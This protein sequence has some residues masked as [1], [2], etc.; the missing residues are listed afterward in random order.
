MKIRCVAL[1][2]E[3]LALKLLSSF[4]TKI[5]FLQLEGAFSSAPEALKYLSENEIDCVFLDIEIPNLNGIELSKILNNFSRKPAIVFVS[6]YGKYAI[7]G[8]KL[9]VVDFLLKPYSLEELNSAAQKVLKSL[10][11]NSTSVS[12]V[13]GNDYFFIKIDAK[14]VKL[15]FSEILY[16]ESMRDY[17][18][19]YTENRD[20]PFIPLMTLKKAKS[21]LT[22]NNFLQIN[23]SQIINI[24]K[25]SSY[26]KTS[27][28]IEGKRFQVSEKFQN[29]FEFVK[30]NLL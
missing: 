16:L 17:V 7:E 18:K 29:D 1:D 28:S 30:L 26:G 2:D 11:A 13:S 12:N 21:I 20:V 27:L 14:Q 22:Q 25:I 4:I 6:A 24:S 9:D 23:R 8:F 5:D 10:E 19:I 15:I 3:P